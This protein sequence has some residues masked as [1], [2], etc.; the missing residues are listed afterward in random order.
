[1]LGIVRDMGIKAV[2]ATNKVDMVI[3]RWVKA[4]TGHKVVDLTWVRVTRFNH[5]C[6]NLFVLD[7]ADSSEVPASHANEVFTVS[8]KNVMICLA[9]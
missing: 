1:M 2:Q 3:R 8:S 4:A 6:I 5:R 7:S 9:E